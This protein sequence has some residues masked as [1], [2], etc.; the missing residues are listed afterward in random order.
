[1]KTTTVP[2]QVTTVEDRLAGNLSL[3]QLLLLVCPV[4]VSCLIYVV[5]PPFIK[6]SIFKVSICALL[7]LFFAV[8]SIRIRG[9][10]VMMWLLLVLKY[11][12]RPRYYL[13][14]KNDPVFR[15]SEDEPSKAVEPLKAQKPEEDKQPVIDLAT[16]DLARLE[17][18][19]ADPRSN[20]NFKQTKNGVLSVHI[21]EI[22]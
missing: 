5:F 15:K 20:F 9:K 22:Q 8:M 1:M 7:F 12:N 11:R 21:T 19:I 17:I 3:T 6:I 13:Y 4:F 18:A 16:P 14:D 10:I 2:A